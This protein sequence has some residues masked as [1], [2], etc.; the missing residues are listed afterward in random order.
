MTP[1]LGTVMP[2]G[3]LTARDAMVAQAGAGGERGMAA[4]ARRAVFYEALLTAVR[5][6][7]GE[8]KAVTK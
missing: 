5:A 2:V 8:L 7:A 1:D 6:R 3:L 4:T